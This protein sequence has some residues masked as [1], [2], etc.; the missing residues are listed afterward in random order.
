MLN[1]SYIKMIGILVGSASIISILLS[2]TPF[3]PIIPIIAIS[4]LSSILIKDSS[5]AKIVVNMM[6]IGIISGISLSI[7]I[8][9]YV[10]SFIG[11]MSLILNIINDTMV[12]NLEDRLSYT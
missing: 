6:I 7:P 2:N 12:F 1:N 4:F 8:M 5:G 11:L 3:M 10:I 9:Y